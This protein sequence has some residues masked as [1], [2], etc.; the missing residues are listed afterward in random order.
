MQDPPVSGNH[1]ALPACQRLPLWG[2]ALARE[3]GRRRTNKTTNSNAHA[4]LISHTV[5][6]LLRN[7][8]CIYGKPDRGD[9]RPPAERCSAHP[10]G[11]K[12]RTSAACSVDALRRCAPAG[13]AAPFGCGGEPGAF[14][15]RRLC[16]PV[17]R[18]GYPCLRHPAEQQPSG[19]NCRTNAG[20]H[21]LL[22]AAAGK[23]GPCRDEPAR[24]V[25]H[26]GAA[27]RPASG[28]AA[29]DGGGGVGGRPRPAGADGS[30]RPARGRD[31]PALPQRGGHRDARAGSGLRQR[32]HR[33]AGCGAGAGD[34][35]PGRISEPLRCTHPGGGK[36]HPLHRGAEEPFRLRFFAAAGPHFCLHAGLRGGSSGRAR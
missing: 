33:A 22:C 11:E 24:R 28:R 8:G 27:H 32:H 23:A 25:Q 18:G 31:H 21:P 10:S 36:F 2:G 19:A 1:A 6:Y 20:V 15:G 17:G 5:G 4:A 9:G 16:G 26:R 30:V 14:A 7:G 35:R 12:Q 13:R 29:P 3:A 34:R